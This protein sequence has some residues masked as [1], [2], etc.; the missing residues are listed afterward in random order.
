M[1]TNLYGISA[2]QQTNQ[3]WKKANTKEEKT[4]KAKSAEASKAEKADTSGK[5]S[6]TSK[7]EEKVWKP[8]DP[9]GSLVPVQKEG[10]GMVIGDVN[11]SDEAKEYYNKLKQKFHNSDFILVSKDMKSQVEQN[12]SAYA[13]P[14]KLVVLIDEEKIERMA[15]DPSYR[16]KYEGIIAMAEL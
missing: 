9:K 2:Y 4:E 6:E 7:T 8:I 15:A 1:A 11:L 5:T 13:N 10:Y 16:D 14:N 3:T 12:A